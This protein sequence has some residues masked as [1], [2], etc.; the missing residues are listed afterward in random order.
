MTTVAGQAPVDAECTE[1]LGKAHVYTEN[2]DVFDCMLNQ[3]RDS[4]CSARRIFLRLMQTNVGNNNNKF[5]LI[6]LLED[7][8]K[9]YYVWLRW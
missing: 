3:V 9:N 7:N 4:D 5:Y 2:K 8:N 1:L 6:Q